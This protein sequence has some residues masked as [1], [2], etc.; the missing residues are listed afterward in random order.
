MRA[1]RVCGLLVALAVAAC[2]PNPLTEAEARATFSAFKPA[3]V[4]LQEQSTALIQNHGLDVLRDPVECDY[5]RQTASLE[6]QER[7]RSVCIAATEV[8]AK[9]REKMQAALLEWAAQAAAR[10]NVQRV[11][12]EPS[13]VLNSTEFQG[14]FSGGRQRVSPE[15]GPTID[16]FRVGYGVYSDSGTGVTAG[17]LV[18]WDFF[19]DQQ[20]IEICAQF[21]RLPAKG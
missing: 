4:R 20:K 6:Q 10:D 13:P 15:Q 7:L 21:P 5:D 12:F 14:C 9:R 16:G 18:E 11:G 8:L 1:R 17:I 19:I 2:G 3:L